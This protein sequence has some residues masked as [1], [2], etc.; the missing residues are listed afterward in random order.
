MTEID[1]VEYAVVQGKIRRLEEKIAGW[2]RQDA[3]I[4]HMLGLLQKEWADAVRIE[5]DIQIKYGLS[6]GNGA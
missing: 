1:R 4:R 5:K 6:A 2:E 3:T